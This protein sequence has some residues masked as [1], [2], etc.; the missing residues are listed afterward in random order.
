MGKNYL[1]LLNLNDQRELAEK[2]T[3]SFIQKAFLTEAT[4]FILADNNRNNYN[5]FIWTCRKV[6]LKTCNIRIIYTDRNDIE[7]IFSQMD[8]FI[9]TGNPSEEKFLKLAE[10][11]NVPFKMIWQEALTKQE[12]RLG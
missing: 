9:A 4:L 5:F 7:Q 12:S 2:I 10:K 1:F 6:Y 3:E 11:N 8:F